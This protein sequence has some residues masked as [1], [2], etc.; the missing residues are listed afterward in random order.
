MQPSLLSWE[1]LDGQDLSV[2]LPGTYDPFLVALS[3]VIASVAAYV[4]L[5]L[6]EWISAAHAPGAK[7]LRLATGAATMGVGVWAMHFLGMLAFHLPIKVRYDVLLTLGSVVP[8]MLASGIMLHIISRVRVHSWQLFIGGMLMGTGI[9]AMHY[10]GMAAMRLDAVMRYDALLIG[11]SIIVAVVLAT[12]ALY[13]TFVASRK[14]HALAHW[15]RP[16]AALLMG[17]AI[18]GMHYTGMAAAYFFPGD[19]SYTVETTVDPLWLGA[20]VSL[21]AALIMGLAI[22]V[23]V[24]DRRLAV[25]VAAERLSYSRLLEAIESVSA[26]FSLYDAEDRLVLCNGRYRELLYPGL[27]AVVPTAPLEQILRSAIE[28]GLIPAAQEGRDAWVADRIAEHQNPPGPLVQQ[29]GTGPWIRVDKRKTKDGDTVA[30]YT[31]ITELKKAESELARAMHEA[32][33]ARA[34]AEKANRAKSEFLAN[35]SHELRTPLNGILGYAQILKRD[36]RLTEEQQ[37]GVDVIKRSGEHLLSLINDILDLAKIEAQKFELSATSFH[38]PA[39][40]QHIA[41]LTR[42]RAEQAGLTFLYEPLPPL[43]VSVQGDEKRLQQV[44]LNLLG[45]AIKFTEK[46]SVTLK[47]GYHGAATGQKKLRFQVE[48]TGRG[49][50]ADKLEEIFLPFQQLHVPG[51]QVE[52]T[53]LGLAITKNLVHLMGGEIRVHAIPD[54]GSTFWVDIELPEVDEWRPRHTKRETKIVGFKGERRHI[55][56]V[57]DKWENRQLIGNLL[58][59]LGF[60]VSEAADGQ[61]GV[62]KAREGRP[63][64]ILMDL[65]MPVMNGLE[66]TRQVRESPELKEVIVIACSAS[67]FAFNRQESLGAGCNDFLTKPVQ[68]EDLF[69]MVGRYLNIQWMYEP[70]SRGSDL[71]QAVVESLVAPPPE[72]LTVLLDLVRKGKVIAIRQEAARLEQLGEAYRPFVAEVRRMTKSFNLKEL[73]QWLTPYLHVGA[74]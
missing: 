49:I 47:V 73:S 30:V 16:G 22:F 38:L 8:A 6:A 18:A 26:G 25:T 70:A 64:L 17:V 39:L 69:A 34:A 68:A 60:Q 58:V 2:A 5:A 7:R 63:D 9:S 4:A 71:G 35:M 55:L 32:R 31:D 20:G 61:E 52:G 59:P 33:E 51:Q 67:A 46:G 24:V 23:T 12:T 21:I 48:D 3:V 66:A 41:D 57:D 62:A 1:L 43:P 54:R 72:E 50:P 65:V 45:N 14:E 28:Q 37:A 13:T 29:L 42:I 19:G 36:H 11:V 15:A 10:T 56:V 40:L 44:L 74:K 27:E 53:G